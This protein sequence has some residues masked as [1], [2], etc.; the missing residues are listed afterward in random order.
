ML[1]P[2]SIVSAGSSGTPGPSATPAVNASPATSLPNAPQRAFKITITEI[3]TFGNA[4]TRVLRSVYEQTASS[5]NVA[6]VAA[7]VNNLPIPA[8]HSAERQV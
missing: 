7:V 8:P 5:I 4:Q 1:K 2:T 3:E 6:K